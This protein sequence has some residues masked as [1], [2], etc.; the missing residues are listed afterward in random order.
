[1]QAQKVIR[2]GVAYAVLPDGREFPLADVLKLNDPSGADYT[3]MGEQIMAATPPRAYDYPPEEADP[4]T[5]GDV[6][7]GVFSEAFD[8]AGDIFANAGNV[9]RN[10][11]PDNVRPYIS[12]AM[13][14]VP[15]MALGGIATVMGGLETGAAALGEVGNGALEG[16]QGLLGYQPRYAPGVGAGMLA[17]DLMGMV[18][19]SG[20]GPEGRIAE[21]TLRLAKPGLKAA[22][23]DAGLRAVDTPTQAL[24]RRNIPDYAHLMHEPQPYADIGSRVSPRMVGVD[25]S[26]HLPGAARMTPAEREAFASMPESTWV[27]PATGGDR[28]SQA[29]GAK[30]LP[31]IRAQGVYEGPMGREVNPAFVARSYAT[32][33]ELAATEALRGYVDGQG[34]TPWT[35]LGAGDEPSLFISRKTPGPGLLSEIAALEAAGAPHNLGGVYDVGTGYVMRNFGDGA[36]DTGMYA[37]QAIQRSTG[38]RPVA[39]TVEGGYPGYEGSWEMGGIAATD[40]LLQYLDA[41]DPA[42]ASALRASPEVRATALDRMMRDNRQS[43]ALGGVNQT[44]QSGRGTIARPGD[45]LENLR[46]QVG[47]TKMAEI[48]LQIPRL[49]RTTEALPATHFSHQ[50]LDVI[51]PARAFS[52]AQIKGAERGLPG[53]YP[54]QSYLGVGVGQP[55][56]YIPENGVGP[57]RHDVELNRS[58]LLD[59]SGG[60]GDAGLE[61]DMI[62]SNL[63]A[64][65]KQRM[66]EQHWDD[67]RTSYAMRVAKERGYDGLLHPSHQLGSIAT[68]FYPVTVPR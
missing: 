23:V 68:S 57:I 41:A 58:G 24:M 48:P 37:R 1:M 63:R 47:R 30:T 54:S 62:V 53:P 17:R 4:Y 33:E 67:L 14:Y 40:Q 46:D 35:R 52:N 13:S 10:M 27:D 64:A 50:P 18:E 51:D 59:I 55:G 36:A 49:P 42:A 9:T 29:I 43:A 32:Q 12:P 19:A 7:K 25:H 22:A 5:F 2:D 56:G 44:L 21:A 28:L 38:M 66:P 39:T 31:T 6:T 34:A 20:F 26:P 45:W 11:V 16:V 65:A 15:D 3:P 8:P 60:F 61:A